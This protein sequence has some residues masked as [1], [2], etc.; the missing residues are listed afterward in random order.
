MPAD[1]G[2]GPAGPAG[3]GQRAGEQQPDQQVLHPGVRPGQLEVEHPGHLAGALVH[4][5]V[6]GA[7][8]TVHDL[9]GQVTGDLRRPGED[10]TGGRLE[11]PHPG[12]GQAGVA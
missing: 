8:V 10:V 12:R 2:G 11:P 1:Q 9:G 7:Q 6:R 5:R 3:P 4:Q